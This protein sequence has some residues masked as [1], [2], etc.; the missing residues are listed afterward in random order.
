MV[1]YRPQEPPCFNITLSQVF[2]QEWH[3][4]THLTSVFYSMNHKVRNLWNFKRQ[5]EP[6][7]AMLSR[8]YCEGHFHNATHHIMAGI[9]KKCGVLV[10]GH[11]WLIFRLKSIDTDRRTAVNQ[12]NSSWIYGWCK[13]LMD[14]PFDFYYCR[15][16]ILSVM[17]CHALIILPCICC[18][19][20]YLV[21]WKS[22][23]IYCWIW[24]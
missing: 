23:F 19:C 9:K 1:F 2:S 17:S 5:S 22:A 6:I 24:D 13:G 18:A 20:I 4:L 21:V 8:Q 3:S 11:L 12:C 15:Y 16:I 10:S 14:V 7:I